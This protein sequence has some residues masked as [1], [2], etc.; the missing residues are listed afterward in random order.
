ML[1]ENVTMPRNLLMSTLGGALEMTMEE[2]KGLKVPTPEEADKLL[3]D[4][5]FGED[6]NNPSKNAPDMK[7]SNRDQN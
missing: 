6:W 5:I 4:V 2:Q 1:T 3:F 7:D